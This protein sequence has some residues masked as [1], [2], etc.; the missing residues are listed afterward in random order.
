MFSPA[1]AE[2]R[3]SAAPGRSSLVISEN[4]SEL[5]SAAVRE[6]LVGSQEGNMYA[7]SRADKETQTPTQK[8]NR[9]GEVEAE[10]GVG[11]ET[12]SSSP[13]GCRIRQPSLK[14]MSPARH[15]PVRESL[16]F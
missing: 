16:A 5:L 14:L 13:C 6:T 12:D 11:L 7:S 1:L 15:W 10:T 9:V 3:D 2:W 8:E 4:F